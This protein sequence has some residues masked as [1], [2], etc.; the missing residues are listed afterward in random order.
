M[1]LALAETVKFPQPNNNLTTGSY[2]MI[3]FSCSKD[4]N[5]YGGKIGKR[6]RHSRLFTYVHV[7]KSN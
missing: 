1:S 2:N 7:V 3:D 5:A 6:S 4:G